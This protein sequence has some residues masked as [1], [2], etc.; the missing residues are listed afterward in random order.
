MLSIGK[1]YNYLLNQT[2]FKAGHDRLHSIPPQIVIDLTN[3]CNLKCPLCP[4]GM[5]IANREK[6]IMNIELFEKIIDQIRD[7]TMAI[8]LY[9]WGEPLL[10]GDFHQYC[11]IAKSKGFVV[12]AS[13]NL[14]I[15][16]DHDKALALIDCGLDRLIVSLDG[17][18][19]RTYTTYRKKGNFSHVIDN[20]ALLAKIKREYR[21]SYPLIITQLVRHRENI[22]DAQIIARA[23]KKL[24]ADYFSLIDVLLPLGEGRNRT[25][26]NRWVTED[27][28][29]EPER[30][31]D[32]P[33]SE[34]GRPCFHLWKLPVI[35]H[36]G[37]ISPCCYVYS[38]KHDFGNLN[39]S[40]FRDI[41]N[42]D[43]FRAA[44]KMFK[45]G[46]SERIEPCGGC[47]L[48]REHAGR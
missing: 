15:R 9:N 5:A 18:S 42:S 22:E 20:L 37:T 35:N 33:E 36:D 46:E 30:S 6:G 16:L 27:R 12:S 31:Y 11:R 1:I 29:R 25:L 28:L 47:C 24:G 41:W 39:Y 45:A 21:K 44:R 26:I 3:I 10:V 17:L 38:K 43:E 4:T 7:R 34:Q 40:D 13:T 14:N 48:F 19:K 32:L 23:F 8:H 2:E